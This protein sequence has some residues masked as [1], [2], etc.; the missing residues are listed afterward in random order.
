MHR[1]QLSCRRLIWLNPLLGSPSYEPLT[2][3]IQAALPYVDNFLPVHN[4]KSLEELGALLERLGE[5]RSLRHQ[6]TIYN[7]Y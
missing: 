3:G 2:R 1:L 6:D 5:S 7:L 4:L